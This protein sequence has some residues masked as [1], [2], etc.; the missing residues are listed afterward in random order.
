VRLG[1][2][3]RE[4]IERR[5]GI[6]QRDGIEWREGIE[7]VPYIICLAVALGNGNLIVM[8]D[9]MDVVRKKLQWGM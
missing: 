3:W 2:D 4:G 9:D 1:I 6:E 5:D 8:R 7:Y